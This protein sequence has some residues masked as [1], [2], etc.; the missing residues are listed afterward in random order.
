MENYNIAVGYNQ[1]FA[2]FKYENL[3]DFSYAYS[4]LNN[5]LL[6]QD[7]KLSNGKEIIKGFYISASKVF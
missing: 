2:Q 3:N 4:T 5:S 6:M 7:S 1:N